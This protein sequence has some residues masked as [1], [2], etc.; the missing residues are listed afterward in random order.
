MDLTVDVGGKVLLKCGRVR[1]NII[2]APKSEYPVLPE[3][4]KQN[5][6]E[7][8]ADDVREMVEKTLFATSTDETR[9]V[10]NGVYWTAR[11][12]Q[13]DMVATDGRRLAFISKKAIPVDRDFQVIV[14]AKVLGELERLLNAAKASGNMLVSVT[15]NQ[16]SFQFQETTLISRL[17]SGSFPNYQQLFQ[18]KKEV[19]VTLGT[20]E[21]LATTR[22]A[23]L[24][25]LD[26]G[27]SVRI[28]LHKGAMQV[29]SSSQTLEFNDE[30]AVDYSGPEFKIAF[31]PQFMADAIKHVDS[32]KLTI[33]FTTPVLPTLVEPVGGGD[34]RFVI[35]PMRA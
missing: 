35:M 5:A 21:L 18:G 13:L 30:I 25:T 7:M 14:P 3:F 2:G 26:R 23:A 10:L 31:N 27:G 6:F 16:I 20:Q 34:Y 1:F 33:S 12:G 11:K 9:H 15:D 4:I 32:E 8:A 19:V 17:V 29:Q 24:C 28:T 22:R